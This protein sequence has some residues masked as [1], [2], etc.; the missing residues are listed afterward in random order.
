MVQIAGEA[1]RIRS[2]DLHAAMTISPPLRQ[3][4]D[5]YIQ[6]L[7]VQHAQIVLCVSRHTLEERLAAWLLT[8]SDR[9]ESE[10]IFITHD[11][12]SHMLGVRRP[13]VT[14][15]IGSLEAGGAVTKGRGRILIADRAKLKRRSCECYE[16]MRSEY[17][18][19]IDAPTGPSSTRRP[20]NIRSM[21]LD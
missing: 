12:V 20:R 10:K 1:L 9:I 19:L 21:A 15:A 7:M 3:A 8:I 5:R 16:N 14:E 18:G 13:S 4:L 11:L 17:V 2:F 6:A